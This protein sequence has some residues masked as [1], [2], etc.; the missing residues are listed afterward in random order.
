MDCY[1][2]EYSSTR[3]LILIPEWAHNGGPRKLKEVLRSEEGRERL[4]DEVRA[5]GTGSWNDLWLT[6]FKH[7]HNQRFEG[8]SVAEA[9]E[10]MGKSEV[11]ALCDLL[12]DEDLQTSY[13]SPGPNLSTLPDFMTHP[14]TMVG[15]ARPPAGG[16]SQPADLRH[17]PDHPRPLRSRRGVPSPWRRRSGR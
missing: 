14:L 9:A 17:L 16:L 2:Y 10:M 4:R 1:P 13:V 11:D 8:R 5:R 7:P 15:T 6:Y 3:A 12:L